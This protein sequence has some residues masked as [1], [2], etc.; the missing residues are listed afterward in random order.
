VLLNSSNTGDYTFLKEIG[1][2]V[3]GKVFSAIRFK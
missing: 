2:G 3:N 1:H